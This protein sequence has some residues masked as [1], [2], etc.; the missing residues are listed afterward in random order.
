[1]MD[2]VC[3]FRHKEGFITYTFSLSMYRYTTYIYTYYMYA[4]AYTPNR[5]ASHCCMYI[6]KSMNEATV[7][8][9]YL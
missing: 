5:I 7:M 3:A 1:M 6:C 2:L 8:G 9:H 4:Y